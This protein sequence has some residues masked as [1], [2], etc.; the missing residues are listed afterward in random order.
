MAL[1]TSSPSD[2]VLLLRLVPSGRTLLQPCDGISGCRHTALAA[3]ALCEF[4]SAR[5]K[6]TLVI[7]Y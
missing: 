2:T 1:G 6:F 5:P 7:K 3:A 4:P